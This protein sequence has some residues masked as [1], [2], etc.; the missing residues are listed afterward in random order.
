MLTGMFIKEIFP[1][2]LL[3]RRYIKIVARYCDQNELLDENLAIVL[4]RPL[5]FDLAI[6]PYNNPPL[7]ELRLWIYPEDTQGLPC[8]LKTKTLD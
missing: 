1:P 3:L 7:E 2:I 8:C 5:P 4:E 6:L